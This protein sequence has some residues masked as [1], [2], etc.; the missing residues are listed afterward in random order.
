MS[1]L[2]NTAKYSE[3][4]GLGNHQEKCVL[5]SVS[6]I[7]QGV[8]EMLEETG[9]RVTCGQLGHVRSVRGPTTPQG[10]RTLREETT[11]EPVDEVGKFTNE[12]KVEII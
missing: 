12:V 6:N 1:Q 8:K 11:R 5:S 2:V 3:K 9:E 10:S 7:S 4:T